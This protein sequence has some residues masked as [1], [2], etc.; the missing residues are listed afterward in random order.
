MSHVSVCPSLC[1]REIPMS[2]ISLKFHLEIFFYLRAAM[3]L[4]S[5]A[6]RF[7]DH[8]LHGYQRAG[9]VI[10]NI[11]FILSKLGERHNAKTFLTD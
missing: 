10:L 4:E 5:R 2:K 3:D 9:G 7:R 11:P 8:L 1:M 6:S